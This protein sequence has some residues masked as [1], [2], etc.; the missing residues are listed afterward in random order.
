MILI[1]MSITH[2]AYR[3]RG[4]LVIPPLIFALIWFDWEIEEFFVWPLGISLFLI[5]II[6][7]LWAQQHLHYGLKVHKRLTITGPYSFTRNPMYI[8]NILICLG[9]TIISELLWFVPIAFLYYSFLYS[10]VVRYEETH[11]LEKYG[12]FYRRYIIEVPR[13]FP[14]VFHCENLGIINEYFRQSIMVELPRLGLLLP[15]ILKEII[16]KSMK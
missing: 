10:L 13:W 8:G 2:I 16:D 4:F 6:L 9:A 11:L 1:K 7:R 14:K 15:Y 3:F 5:G 12:E